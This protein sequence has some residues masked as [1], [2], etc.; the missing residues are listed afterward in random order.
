MEYFSTLGI[1]FSENYDL[2]LKVIWNKIFN[3]IKNRIPMISSRFFILYQKAVLIN[4][5]LASKLWYVAHVYPLPMDIAVRINKEIFH[6]LWGSWANP[7]KRDILYN[8]KINGG[9][10]LLNIYLKSKS[11]LVNTVMK[12]FLNSE[13]DDLVRYYM[14]NKIGNMFNILNLP[15][16]NSHRNAPYFDF[17]VDTIRK[18]SGHKNFPNL[19]SKDIYDI[20]LPQ[21]KPDIE[22][23]YPYYDWK[24]IWIMLNFR[25]I[26]V[27]DRNVMY[28]YLYEIL[29][30]NKRR[31]ETQQR[32]SPLCETC[33][34]QESNIH[35]FYYCAKVQNYI[36]HMW[37]SI[38]KL[39]KGI[40]VGIPQ[41]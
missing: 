2:A 6:F 40:N 26:N 21:C 39:T 36:L 20:I 4:S 9:I 11:I 25:Y 37:H 32:E 24:N 41:N 3:K 31:Y 23:L 7:L 1:I 13:R 10:G 16:K 15:R 30:T 35:K 17:T 33:Q 14:A 38:R 22:T 29:P 19:K 12:N 28:K 5:L 27:Y 8:K 18:C 34:V